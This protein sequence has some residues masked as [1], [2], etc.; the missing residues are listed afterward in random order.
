MAYQVN[1]PFFM[2]LLT[3]WLIPIFSF[4]G[5]VIWYLDVK[6]AKNSDKHWSE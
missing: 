4:A 5:C 6:K 2:M 3:A 1:I